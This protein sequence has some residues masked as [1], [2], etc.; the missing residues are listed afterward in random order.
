LTIR[1]S[2]MSVSLLTIAAG[3]AVFTLIVLLLVVLI[4]FAKSRLVPSGDVKITVNEQ[5]TITVPRGGK[6]LN[7]LANEGIFVSSACGGGGTC[8]QC[9][10]KV[11]AGGGD[12]LP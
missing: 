12:I 3:V 11:H 4:L 1:L 7:A 6:L 5:K 9:L 10:V 2:R 8:A